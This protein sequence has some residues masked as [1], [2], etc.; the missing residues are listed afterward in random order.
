MIAAKV[1]AACI[2]RRTSKAARAALCEHAAR[3]VAI[4][5]PFHRAV[6]RITKT[7]DLTAVS[8]LIKADATITPLSD[9]ETETAHIEGDAKLLNAIST[10]WSECADI[11]SHLAAVIGAP[12]AADITDL[13]KQAS[14]ECKTQIRT[15]FAADEEEIRA[16]N[17]RVRN[18]TAQAR[19]GN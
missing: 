11:E 7:G 9:N 13:A 8:P 6:F 12:L 4:E 15:H 14:V 18:F 5:L 1:I 10:A 16:F 17:T 19:K 2:N 3:T